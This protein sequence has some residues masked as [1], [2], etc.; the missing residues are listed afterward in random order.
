MSEPNIDPNWLNTAWTWIAGIGTTAWGGWKYI[1]SKIGKQNDHIEK[2]Y[3]NAENDRRFTR[4]L[5][6]KAMD[7]IA[8]NQRQIVQMLHERK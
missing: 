3:Q 4:D 1:D 6:D 8:S 5:H 7:T 2:L